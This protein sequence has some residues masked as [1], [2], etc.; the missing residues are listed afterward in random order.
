MACRF[1]NVVDANDGNMYFGQTLQEGMT[2]FAL[3]DLGQIPVDNVG[4]YTDWV[5]FEG[6]VK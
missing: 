6:I 2:T 4:I 3:F 5:E 1:E